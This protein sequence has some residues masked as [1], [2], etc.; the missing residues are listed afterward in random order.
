MINPYTRMNT[1]CLRCCGLLLLLLPLLTRAQAPCDRPELLQA[2]STTDSTA[3][4]TWA[5]VGDAYDIEIRE[6]AQAFTGIPTHTLNADPPFEVLGLT[7]V[8]TTVF[9]CAPCAAT[10]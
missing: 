8:R 10:R 2:S 5:D 3:Q 7:P 4:L 9:R 6:A 1:L